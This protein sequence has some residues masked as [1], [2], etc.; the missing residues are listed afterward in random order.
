[1]GTLTATWQNPTPGLNQRPIATVKV[2][3]AVASSSPTFSDVQNSLAT[4]YVQQE[5]DPG[6]Y[7]LRLI[8]V[9]SSG[10]ESD[11]LD[12][13]FSVAEPAE[14]KPSQASNVSISIT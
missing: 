7:I 9:S 2:Q 6:S 1:M 3:L 5:I 13:S 11:P 8:E 10:M 12:T 4:Q 14:V